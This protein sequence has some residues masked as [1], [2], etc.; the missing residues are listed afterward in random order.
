MIEYIFMLSTYIIQL[1]SLIIRA[2]FS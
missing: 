1:S 2:T